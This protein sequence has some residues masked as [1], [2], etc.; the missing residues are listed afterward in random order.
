MREQTAPRVFRSPLHDER[1]ASL[2]GVALGVT[3]TVCF[4]TGVLSHL[5]QDPPSWFQWPSRPAGLYR[6][7]QG[8]HVATGLASIPLLLA[9]LWVVL[10]KL[11][12]W[13]PFRSVAHLVER[14]A[15]FP[16]VAG[17]IF[18]L[19]SG[20]ADTHLWYPW[21]FA[22][23]SA[24][25]W[26][27]WITIGALVVHLGAKWATTRAALLKEGRRPPE[28]HRETASAFDR[29]TFLATVGVA[30]GAVTLFTV[31]QTVSPL[32]KLALLAARRP[33]TGPQGFPVNRTAA[34][35]G[36]VEAARATDYR[37]RVEGKVRRP[38]VFTRDEL[39]A[40]PQ[41]EATLP[42]A[43]VEGWSTS[44]R[45]RGVRVRD[46][47]ERAGAASDTEVRVHSLQRRRQYRFSDL[48]RSQAH[49]PDTLLALEVNGEPLDIDHG[50]P[51]RLIGPNRPGVQQTKWVTRLVVR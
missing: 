35:A 4:V 31:G 33:D 6:V 39:R 42:I 46:L 13:P 11:F 26:V 38:L 1:N 22:F 12:A 44:Q 10:P 37:L 18:E 45:W 40:L 17:G 24:H 7:T 27:A 15:I 14:L 5:I 2:L 19:F 34:T 28:T 8:V 29:R 23:R 3:F 21:P 16:L 50:Y 49:D 30:A 32:R 48:N 43:C 36:V 47:L 25:Y 9:K 20:L 41:H 51:L